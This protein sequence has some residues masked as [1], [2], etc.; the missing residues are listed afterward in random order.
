M[1]LTLGGKIAAAAV[2]DRDYRSD[3]ECASISRDCR[4]FCDYVTIYRRKEIENFL[5]VPSA[6]DR[7]CARRVADQ[8]KRTQTRIEYVDSATD[9]LED[10]CKKRKSYVTAQ[11]LVSRR[12]FE[13]T[14]SPGVNE[15]TINEAGL[16]EFESQWSETLRRFELVPGKEAI[17]AINKH[18]Q[19]KYGV[20]IT[21]MSIVNAMLVD[22]IADDLRR[23]LAGL[24]EFT[25]DTIGDTTSA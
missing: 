3:G 15:T 2:L 19:E 20:S 17:S 9:L 11:Y 7:A 13:R 5:L 14:N 24:L 23:L 25:S 10:Y 1:E 4:I 12:A 22:E 8:A 16:T 18:L 6:I 21:P